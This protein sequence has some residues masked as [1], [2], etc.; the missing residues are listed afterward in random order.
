MCRS[1][2][3]DARLLEQIRSAAQRVFEGTPVFLA[4]AYGSRIAGSPSPKS[5]LD[6]GYYAGDPPG[7][8]DVSLREEMTLLDKLSRELGLEVDLRNLGPAPLELRGQVLE[9]GVR[10]YSSD[11]VRRV[12][13]E[14]DLLGRYHDA[15]EMFRRLHE[16]RLRSIAETGL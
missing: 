11:E 3:P 6:I 4:Y 12:G 16:E 15:K 7:R 9:T 14:R 1:S 5:D 2:S 13:L 8:G 10:I